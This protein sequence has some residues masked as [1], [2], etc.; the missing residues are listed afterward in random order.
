[1]STRH[2]AS[3]RQPLEIALAGALLAAGPAFPCLAADPPRL[4]LQ[5]T[6]DQLR[7]DL[8]RRHLH[9]LGP[10]G[11]RYL[12]ERGTVYTD[13]HHAHA[14][15]E[16]IVGHVTLATG[17]HP[18]AHGMIGNV[19]LDRATGETVY[20]IEDPRYR[21]LTAGADV[22]DETEIDP[23]QRAASTE[24]RSPAAILVSTFSDE[25]ALHTAGR[26]KVFA[27]SVKDRGAVS[28]AG[29]AGKA[30]WF[31]KASGEFVTSDY[32][33]DAYP[34]WV[35]EFNARRP[36]AQY[37]GGSWKL[38]R[39]RSTYL[40]G[41]AD[42]QPWETALPGFGR[43]F[44]HP[45]GDKDGKLFTTLLTVSPA[46]D[47][48]T[49]AFAKAL[50]EGERLGADEVPD[51]LGVS[52]SSTDYV[53]HIFGPSSL[54]AEDNLLRLDRTIAELLAFVDEQVGLD[55]TLIVLSADHGGPEAP[56]FLRELG[57]NADYVQ[58]DPWTLEPA[59]EALRERFSGGRELISGYTHPYLNL[60]REMIRARGL[61]QGEVEEAV[62]EELMRLDGV[63]LAVS[64]TAL[65]HSRLPDTPMLRSILHNFNPR[66]SGDIFVVFEPQRFL[67]DFEG[68][69]VASTH[70]SPW[71]YDTYRSTSP[72]RCPRCSER[73]RRRAPSGTC[74]SR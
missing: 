24:G 58:P 2:R 70:G 40:F 25:L 28:M 41:G 10:D 69:E 12:L 43:V 47:A 20:N 11:L 66:R 18:A 42:D 71:S 54:E 3:R 67:N 6:V 65:R 26:A 61:D 1:M 27:V 51:Y 8:P 23:T 7:G 13:A 72:A 68:L 30:F 73:I 16:T 49:L 57:I 33:Y 38:L 44:P 50:I 48:M 34:A 53:G 74:W 4:V 17:A 62:A 37:A 59:L 52:F 35:V 15:T 14:N 21:L 31:S 64:S 46:G 55:R 63:Y 60:D 19:W 36:A 29:H 32:Y 56:G 45:F 39:D 9:Q 22:D 5:I